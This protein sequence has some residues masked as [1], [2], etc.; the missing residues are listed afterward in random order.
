[1]VS[2]WLILDSY[3]S[4]IDNGIERT[5]ADRTQLEQEVVKA[6]EEDGIQTSPPQM[7]QEQPVAQTTLDQSQMAQAMPQPQPQPQPENQMQYE[8]IFPNDPLGAMI[9]RNK[10][11]N[12]TS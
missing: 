8:N 7:T 10:R 11:T 5:Y 2:C 1:M 12:R 4:S 9:A 3:F 6:A